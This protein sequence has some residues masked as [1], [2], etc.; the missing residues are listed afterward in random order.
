MEFS[1]ASECEIYNYVSRTDNLIIVKRGNK[2]GES[3]EASFDSTKL[4]KRSRS[5]G[6]VV[7]SQNDLVRMTIEDTS[8]IWRG[9]E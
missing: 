8:R 4:D 2:L 9:R 3:N 5:W 7:S 6:K 1:A